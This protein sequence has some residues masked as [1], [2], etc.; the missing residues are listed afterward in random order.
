[1]LEAKILPPTYS[2]NDINAGAG[3]QVVTIAPPSSTVAGKTTKATFH[4][5]IINN[6]GTT[7]EID[8]YDGTSS[9]AASI[10]KIRSPVVG[11]YIYDIALNSGLFIDTV[12]GGA[13]GDL[14]VI[15]LQE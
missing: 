4:G 5:I 14:T 8:I 9:S 7:W 10:A 3:T 11:P 15:Y 2:W 1:M 13:V 12:K 6:P